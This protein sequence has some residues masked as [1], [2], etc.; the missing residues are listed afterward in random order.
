MRLVSWIAFLF[1]ISWSP[2]QPTPAFSAGL[3]E[4]PFRLNEFVAGP[5]RDW[6][7]NGS[8]SSRDD[9]WIEV[10]NSGASSLDLTGYFISDGD[11][12]PRFAFSGSLAPGARQVVFGGTALEWERTNGYP[13]FGL[14]LAN[15]GDAVLLWR[16]AGAETLLVD[17]YA[18]RNHEAA[19]DRSVG[20]AN[21]T[22]GWELFD[23]FNPYTGTVPPAGNLCNPSLASRQ[24][25]GV[26]PAR[27]ISW[28]RL[29]TIYR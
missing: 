25:C 27:V 17:A 4:S 8:F 10:M 3:P 22:G 1:L 18:Y 21:D 28:G 16:I 2:A 20:R 6:D 11:S 26:T 13:A 23:G 12:I 19:P 9:E 7:G 5:A 15:S 24:L 14:S 29:K